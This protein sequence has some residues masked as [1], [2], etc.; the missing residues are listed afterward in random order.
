MK[1]RTAI[2]STRSALG[3]LIAGKGWREAWAA[4]ADVFGGT[5]NRMRRPYENSA[6]VFRAIQH[7]AGP[8]SSRAIAFQDASKQQVQ[9]PDTE[10]FWSKPGTAGENLPLSRAD[11]MEASLVWL[12]LRGKCFWVLDDSWLTRSI[13]RSPIILAR[14]DRMTPIRGRTDN[15]LLGW[16]FTDGAGSR[17]LLIPD[18][19]IWPHFY[20]PYDPLDGLAPWAAARIASESDYAAGVFAR[21]LM[22]N[23]G[24]R[25][26][27]VI[28]KGGT[29]GD[30]QRQQIET[31]LRQKRLL[32]SR[33][34]F[35]T[36]FL[37]AD[38]AVEDPKVQSTDAE[39][40][41]QRLENRH[42]IFIAFG[43]PASMADVTASYSVGSA[44]DRYRLIE[45]TCMPLASKL[46]EGIEQIE[47]LRTRRALTLSL[48][49]DEHSV[50]QQVRQER[51]T[52]ADKF[53]QRGAP[54]SVLNRWLN[55]GLPEYEGWGI[56]Y[57]PMSMQPVSKDTY[58][59]QPEMEPAK[60]PGEDAQAA[61]TKITSAET[62]LKALFAQ[63]SEL[64]VNPPAPVQKDA[65][66]DLWHQHMVARA[67]SVKLIKKQI[68]K[69]LHDARTETLKNLEAATTTL[70]NLRA[71]GLVDII[72]DLGK[73]TLSLW[74]AMK[75][76]LSEVLIAAAEQFSEEL[77]LDDPWK[78]EDP[79]VGQAVASRENKMK[80]ASE[81]IWKDV[82]ETI[83]EGIEAGESNAKIAARIREAFNGISKE[84]SETIAQT[85]VAA[86]YGQAR[87]RGMQENGVTYKKWLTAR[88]EKVRTSHQDVDGD[89]VGTNEHFHVGSSLL[90]HPGDPNGPAE[91]VINC[92]CVCVAS[93]QPKE[94][95][96]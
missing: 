38:V 30:D 78:M 90:L 25:G 55:L 31:A 33:G 21:N 88:D 56:G 53:A 72:F 12:L 52:V 51:A 81:R 64:E 2:S 66:D 86:A 49:W 15:A 4:G 43:V 48:N 60:P 10:A 96:S 1:L 26:V 93:R 24:D 50:M 92:R 44:S 85:E 70:E 16:N 6:W 54:M 5:S 95:Q 23:N 42:E 73:F 7:I 83:S 57:L 89:I 77:G 13:A 87:Q 37:T 17:H 94:V 9:D 27:Y 39:F 32:A 18:Q 82:S 75:G 79:A 34:E 45:D 19:V 3:K 58:E 47:Y 41:A 28:S 29:L 35:K 71:K 40:V 65:S 69:C 11:F 36:A 68:N 61:L 84:R 67:A 91:E 80:D 59:T 46:G 62:S 63:R 74:T 14:P 22:E 76:G 20:N 8:I